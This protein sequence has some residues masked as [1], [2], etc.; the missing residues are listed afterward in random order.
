M[1]SM[2]SKSHYPG[3]KDQAVPFASYVTLDKLF[4]HSVPQFP[5]LQIG[6]IEYLGGFNNKVPESVLKVH[7]RCIYQPDLLTFFL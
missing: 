1:K 2:G 3:F 7:V 4:S 6:I 5:Y